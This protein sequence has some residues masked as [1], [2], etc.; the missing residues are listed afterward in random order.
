MKNKIYLLGIA[1]VLA[2][3]LIVLSSVA[4]NR[5]GSPHAR[6]TLTARELPIA[7][8]YGFGSENTGLS[9]RIRWSEGAGRARAILDRTKLESLGFDFYRA[10]E[11]TG[12]DHHKTLLPRE[13]YAVLEYGGD[14]WKQLLRS[15]QEKLSADL[16]KAGSDAQRERLKQSYERF[17][18]TAS[19]LVLVDVG[20]DRAVLRTRYPDGSRYIVAKARVSAYVYAPGPRRNPSS[21]R[22]IGA[23]SELLP[24]TVYVPRK[25]H[26]VLQKSDPELFRLR[27]AHRAGRI[28]PPR[29]PGHPC[30]WTQR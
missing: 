30:L 13:A 26:A 16:A 11:N 14:A 5:S 1:L 15:R 8:H 9:L 4:Y 2:I 6:L 23:V 3:N 29:L 27:W 12:L 21:H 7:W 20:P 19:R 10:V 22:I 17:E 18:K 24:D 28:E 25:F